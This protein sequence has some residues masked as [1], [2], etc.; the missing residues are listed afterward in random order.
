[1]MKKNILKIALVFALCNVPCIM[2][3]APTPAAI[4]PGVQLRQ[5][6]EQIERE[7]VERQMQEQRL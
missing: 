7:R 6:Q 1:M 3:A 2:L 4:D 5:M